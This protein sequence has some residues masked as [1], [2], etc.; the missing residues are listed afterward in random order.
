MEPYR[1]PELPP[2]SAEDFACNAGGLLLDSVEP[3]EGA[4]L[5]EVRKGLDTLLN[6]LRPLLTLVLEGAH[7]Q[8]DRSSQIIK[9]GEWGHDSL[10]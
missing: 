7:P 1:R 8:A 10:G 6:L 9:R 4:Q 2:G 3:R 5:V